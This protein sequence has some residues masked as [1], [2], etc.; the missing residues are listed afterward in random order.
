MDLL[1]ARLSGLD[2]VQSLRD[3]CLWKISGILQVRSDVQGIV[4]R[5]LL[6]LPPDDVV[7]VLDQNLVYV[8]T[9]THLF[10]PFYPCQVLL[11]FQKYTYLW[12]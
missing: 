5:L 1:H 4:Q 6:H 7:E 12:F 3:L 9:I 11:V 2:R 10:A 8:S